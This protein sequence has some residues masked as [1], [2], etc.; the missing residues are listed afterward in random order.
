MSANLYTLVSEAVKLI[1]RDEGLV[2]GWGIPYGGPLDGKDLDGE[3]FTKDTELYLG[4]YKERPLL[5]HHGMDVTIGYEPIGAATKATRKERG[6][7]VE[8]QL[9]KAH[10]YREAVLELLGEGLL[11]YSSGAHPRSIAKTANG[12]I[13]NWFW[14][15][16][17]LT[18]TPA[19]PF[20]MISVKAKRYDD[21]GQLQ[22]L[23]IKAQ[24]AVIEKLGACATGRRRSR[25]SIGSLYRG[26][27]GRQRPRIPTWKNALRN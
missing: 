9:A 3:A 4:A 7:W 10:P 25:R 19:N 13:T 14:Y 22:V 18:P 15:E 11:G 26:V 8:S 5:Y 27:L 1:D 6:M 21:Q 24:A 12:A 23:P 20:A 2:A 16:Q 17:S